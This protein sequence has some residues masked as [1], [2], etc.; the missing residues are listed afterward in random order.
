MD[1][2]FSFV[3]YCCWGFF[4]FEVVE[5]VVLRVFSWLVCVYGYAVVRFWT[6]F[7]GLEK[8][9]ESLDEVSGPGLVEWFSPVPGWDAV[10]FPVRDE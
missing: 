7:V 5:V 6:D 8:R 2:D 9:D 1:V 4:F 3:H 10:L